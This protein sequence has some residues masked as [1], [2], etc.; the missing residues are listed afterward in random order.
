MYVRLIPPPLPGVNI[1]LVKCPGTV[2][3]HLH[4]KFP[5][6]EGVTRNKHLDGLIIITLSTKTLDF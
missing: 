5:R 2:C 6:V 1:S 3:A 4:F